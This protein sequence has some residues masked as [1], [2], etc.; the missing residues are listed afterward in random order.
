MT[1]SPSLLMYIHVC[2]A[3][4][5][6]KN[7]L[8]TEADVKTVTVVISKK[9]KKVIFQWDAYYATL[10]YYLL[11]LAGEICYLL[12][13]IGWSLHA[14]C[15]SVAT[16]RMILCLQ[17]CDPAY[18]LHWFWKL[19]SIKADFGQER[20]FAVSLKYMCSQR[21]RIN[22]SPIL[23][24]KSRNSLRSIHQS[25][26]ILWATMHQLYTVILSSLDLVEAF[27]IPRPYWNVA[28]QGQMYPFR[29]R[30]GIG[31]DYLNFFSWRNT[32]T[33][34]KWGIVSFLATILQEKAFAQQHA[35]MR[36]D[37]YQQQRAES[38]N[39]AALKEA[40]P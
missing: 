39:S 14:R 33:G 20:T 34:Q 11:F 12:F 25:N 38:K 40:C 24:L 32:S 37:P 36:S 22:F 9:Y 6:Y 8:T 2:L 30:D 3:A 1:S 18:E 21:L 17:P 16:P 5:A 4:R 31:L 15:N 19:G 26:S 35:G 23:W 7:Q 27:R 29:Q 13:L 10:I 28:V